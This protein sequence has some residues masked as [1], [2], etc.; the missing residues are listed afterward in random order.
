MRL[1]G[2]R[3]FHLDKVLLWKNIFILCL[4]SSTFE[5]DEIGKNYRYKTN[6]SPVIFLRNYR[7]GRKFK[8]IE[9]ARAYF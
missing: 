6:I 2:T 8:S 1:V 4:E 7:S 3:Q 5:G 9:E